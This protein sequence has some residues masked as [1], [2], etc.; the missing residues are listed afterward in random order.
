[1]IG[2]EAFARAITSADARPVMR[3]SGPI[4]ESEFIDLL[5]AR[6]V[7]RMSDYV[8]LS[9]A[10]AMLACRD[11]GITDILAFAATCSALLGT[12]HGS[13]NFSEAYYRQI[14]REG[15]LAANPMLFAEGVPNAGAA[16]L[17]LMLALKGPC[18]TIIGTR[19]AG[20]DALHLAATRIAS[21]EWDRAIVSAAEEYSPL[22]NAAYEHW[23]LHSTSEPAAP[24]SGQSGGFVAGCGAVTLVLESRGID[25]RTPR[26]TTRTHPF[27]NWSDVDPPRLPISRTQYSENIRQRRSHHQLR[28][29]HLAGP[30]GKDR[31]RASR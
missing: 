5:N 3:D 15:I 19:T 17:S 29:R 31:H 14:V 4:A 10:A 16:H 6:R 12:T 23:G 2:N 9:L 7:R 27:V 8:K 11:A 30:P 25:V 13:S 28:E 18:Q 24:F 20:L 26:V 21:G 1:M 22:V